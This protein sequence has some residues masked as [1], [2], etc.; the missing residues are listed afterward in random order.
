[1]RS[2]LNRKIENRAEFERT[3]GRLSQHFRNLC[4]YVIYFSRTWEIKEMIISEFDIEKSFPIIRKWKNGNK[5]E[6][7][8]ART[9]WKAVD[10]CDYV[11][12]WLHWEMFILYEY[13]LYVYVNKYSHTVLHWLGRVCFSGCRV[14]RDSSSEL[15]CDNPHRLMP[16]LVSFYIQW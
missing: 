1:M 12:V 7:S 2:D 3:F 10:R 16:S 15:S 5:W 11:C 13:V 8:S 6:T 9:R 14:P 4:M